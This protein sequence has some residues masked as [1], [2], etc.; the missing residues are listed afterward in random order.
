MEPLVRF[1]L[2]TYSLRMNCSTPELQRR[3]GAGWKQRCG[4][5]ASW[6]ISDGRQG[7]GSYCGAVEIRLPWVACDGSQSG[8]RKTVASSD[9]CKL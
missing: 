5:F 9:F 2:T 8:P 3:L 6:K 4:N 7:K 1:E